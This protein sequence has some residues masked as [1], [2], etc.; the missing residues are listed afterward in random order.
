MLGSFPEN[1]D[2]P[3]LFSR[4]SDAALVSNAVAFTLMADGIPIIYQ[5]QEQ[6]YPGGDDL[7]NKEANLA[8]RI[9]HR[10]PDISSCC[11]PEPDPKSHHLP[12][13]VVLDESKLGDTV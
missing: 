1:H 3:R 10:R 9:Q 12:R 7:Y 8:E 4:T 11:E 13:S 2:V 5:G 6:S